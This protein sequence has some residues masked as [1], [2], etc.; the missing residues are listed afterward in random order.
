MEQLSLLAPF[1]MENEEPTFLL[2]GAHLE[3]PAQ[4]LA[5][6]HLKWR[7]P[8]GGEMVA[9]NASDKIEDARQLRFRVKLGFNEYRGMRKVQLTVEDMRRGGEAPTER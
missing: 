2:E 4:V 7:L 8:N 6:R 5:G 9:W 3:E 1:G